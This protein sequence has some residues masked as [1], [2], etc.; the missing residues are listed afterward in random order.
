MLEDNNKKVQEIKNKIKELRD[1]L[2]LMNKDLDNFDKK[3]VKDK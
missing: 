1:E 3:K 2:N